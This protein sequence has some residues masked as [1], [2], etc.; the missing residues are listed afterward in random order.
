MA[1]V[2]CVLA[3]EFEDSELE[4][5]RDELRRA[6]HEVE[7]VGLQAGAELTGKRGRVKERVDRSFDEVRPGDY[8][9]LFIPGGHSPDHLRAHPRAVRFVGEMDALGKPILAIC[10]GPQL[11]ISAH[12]VEGRTLTAWKTVQE[13]L[14]LIP[15]VEVHD[16][17]V[18]CDRNWVTSRQ[19]SDIPAFVQAGL[20][21]LARHARQRD[22][23]TDERGASA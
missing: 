22:V 13:D 3:D 1:R 8:D 10:H 21:L 16:E 19:P 7:I 17:A 2:A 11:L 5:P 20:Q 18:V 6:G 14:R 4:V 12:R 9:A 15:G 23:R